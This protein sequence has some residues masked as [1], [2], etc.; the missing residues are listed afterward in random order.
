MSI[1]FT[2]L[3]LPILCAFSLMFIPSW[4]HTMIRVVALSASLF[5]F[6]LSLCLWLQFDNSTGKFQFMESFRLVSPSVPD[7]AHHLDYTLFF[8]EFY[9][10]H[11]FA[12]GVDGISLFF[13]ILTCFLTP[14]CILVFWTSEV[15]VK[16]YC[17]AF[18]ILESLTLA[19]FCVLD[20]LLFYIF[21]E[22]VLIPMFIIIGVWGSRQRKIKAAYQ[23]FIYTF[24][25]SVL[26][27]LAILLL[28]FQAGST[29][30]EVL[31][32]T[33]LSKDRELLLW[34]AFS[35]ALP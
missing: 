26:L 9:S 33:P 24:L 1:L 34:F 10:A 25:G 3:V 6:L 27:L 2:L 5:N 12:I 19:V 18:L 16:E 17:M 4:N 30:L 8:P 32:L 14:V 13:V 22:S 35:P 28:Y 7:L 23:F 31:F 11:Q 20:M 15:A 29:D 21:F